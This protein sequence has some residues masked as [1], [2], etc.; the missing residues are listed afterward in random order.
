MTEMNVTNFSVIRDWPQYL[1]SG[2]LV[3]VRLSSLMVFAPVFSS[4][5]IPPRVKAGFVFAMTIMLAP[6]VA[7][8]RGS[9]LSLNM[10]AVLGELGVGLIFGLTLVLIN[11]A[12]LFAAALLGIEFSFSLVNLMDPN[13]M[14][15]TPVLGQMLGWLGVLVLI[16]AGMDR[17]MLAAI[18][19]SFIFAPVGHASVGYSSCVAL[20]T[21]AAGVFSSGLQLAAP[22]IAATITVEF[23]ITLIGRLSPQ[24]PA[25][26]AGV[27]IK[28][29]IAYAVLVAEL[30]AWPRWIEGRFLAS[31]ETAGRILGQR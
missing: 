14:I 7:T 1:V 30:A 8:L 6:L 10:S 2:I 19:R 25:M 4:P 28:T 31:L 20:M 23:T 17:I 27:P 5:A 3:M 9:K 12:L 18:V 29:L 11:E 16:G 22:V 24:L 21:M 15:E 26:V 13:S